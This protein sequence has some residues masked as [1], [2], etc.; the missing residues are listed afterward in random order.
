M[1]EETYLNEP[2]RRTPVLDT[3]DV[4]VVGAGVAGVAAAVSAARAGARTCLIEKE[5]AP[6]GLATLGLVAIYLP[7]CDGRGNQ[8]IAGMG[9]E[10]LKL[11]LKYGPG[12]IPTC[13]KEGGDPSQRQSHRYRTVFNPASFLLALEE[14]LEEEGVELFYDSRF[15]AVQS[16]DEDNVSAVIVENKSGRGAIE[17][18]AVVDATGDADVAHASGEETVAVDT[19]HRSAWFYSCNDGDVQLHKLHEPFQGK[20]PEGVPTFA[21]HIHDDVTRMSVESRKLILHEL[22]E[23][24][25]GDEQYPIVVP[26]LPQFR[27]TRKLNGALEL[28]DVEGEKFPDRIGRTGD[29][30]ESGPVFSIPFRCLHGK[31]TGNL[32]VAGRCISVTNSMWDIVRAIPTCTVT[33]QASGTAAALMSAEGTPVED[34]DIPRLQSL[35]REQGAIL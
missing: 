34:L 6:G 12:E 3:Y 1:V 4:V 25:S 29:W 9:E 15:C 10:L 17:C 33:G 23:N 7:L 31:R 21:G 11:S 18:R 2:A 26:V 5:N 13:W 14:L 35:L 28:D 32:L 24:S 30:R 19:N 20:T 22:K 8:V 16:T 27:M